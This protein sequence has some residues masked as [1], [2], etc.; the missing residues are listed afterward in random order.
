MADLSAVVAQ[1]QQAATQ[2]SILDSEL[3]GNDLLQQIKELLLGN[4]QIQVESAASADESSKDMSALL[5]ATK[6]MVVDNESNA[7]EMQ[8]SLS[9]L[10]DA[11]KGMAAQK[12]NS[13]LIAHLKSAGGMLK[14]MAKIAAKEYVQQTK[15]G[16]LWTN[17]SKE[18]KKQGAAKTKV[19]EG[20]SDEGGKGG[21]GGD[22][23][24]LDNK[25]IAA[26]MA[27]A[28][29]KALNPVTMVLTFLTKV[30]PMLIVFGLLLYGFIVGYLNGTVAD[31][32]LT[33]VTVII[34][35]VLAYVAYLYIKEAIMFGIKVACEFMKVGIEAAADW[36]AVYV[37]IA[38][39][40]IIAV[41]FLVAAVLVVAIIALAIVGIV[42]AMYFLT[43][44]IQS[45][46]EDMIED[47]MEVFGEQIGEL[48]KLI[49]ST[50]AV[51]ATLVPIMSKM[52][53]ST[54]ETLKTGMEKALSGISATFK[55]MTDTMD[56]LATEISDIFNGLAAAI[57]AS[58]IGKSVQQQKEQAANLTIQ[59]L[60]AEFESNEKMI[61]EISNMVAANINETIAQA[62]SGVGSA[63]S[64]F[65]TAVTDL[66]SNANTVIGDIL[67]AV[68]S[69]FE[70]AYNI[71]TKSTVLLIGKI[72]EDVDRIT[73]AFVGLLFGLPLVGWLMGLVGSNSFTEALKPLVENTAQIKALTKSVLEAV[74]AKRQGYAHSSATNNTVTNSETSVIDSAINTI[75]PTDTET[76]NE[77][78][79][80]LQGTPSNFV[81]A[82]AFGAQMAAVRAQMKDMIE[83]IY[84]TAPEKTS[85]KG[86]F[87][88]W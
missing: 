70:G 68:Y 77:D 65:V 3:V 13:G 88:W 61:S 30:V 25:M 81:T 67:T 79:T 82:Q 36:A 39:I 22:V 83:A 21:G 86:L 51:F 85:K 10:T 57:L 40:A 54:A 75:T 37:I 76:V 27:A 46:M 73:N 29:F 78:T 43:K 6:T 4:N 56:K 7:E 48:K 19:V 69:L 47:I 28:A 64:Q 18:M 63:I 42:I 55:V 87:G 66:V 41:A 26:S 71:I 16:K 50:I 32:V 14:Q 23:P 60:T 8:A 17:I 58:A 52:M 15:Y 80:T 44:A 24:P 49:M 11:S 1:Q 35:A 2:Q 59:S 5:D 53:T 34:A 74:T 20:K 84:K 72:I 33:L 38:V 9:D 62:F 31:F 12:E 45:M